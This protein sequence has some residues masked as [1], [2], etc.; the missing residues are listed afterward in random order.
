MPLTLNAGKMMP[1]YRPFTTLGAR[2]Y[3]FREK[4]EIRGG[5]ASA[6]REARSAKRREESIFFLL[7]ASGL[8]EA[9]LSPNLAKKIT[10]GTQ[11]NPLQDIWKDNSSSEIENS[12]FL[13]T[14]KIPNLSNCL[15]T[16]CF[17]S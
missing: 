6:R 14:P 17:K 7:S 9:D 12:K 3:F 15:S 13:F 1:V 8:A 16:Q 5:A 11:G 10:S 4:R 2:G